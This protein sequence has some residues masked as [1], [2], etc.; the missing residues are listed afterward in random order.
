MRYTQPSDFERL[1][2]NG[3]SELVEVDTSEACRL[4]ALSLVRQAA[5]RVDILSR[6]LDPAMYDTSEFSEAVSRLVIN[7]RRARVRILLRQV[8]PVVKHGHRL[9][10]LAQRLSSFIELRVP[11]GE[12]DDYN[13]AFLMVD[14]AGVIYR[15][16]PA[17]FEATV[18][19]SDRRMAQELG[20]QFDEMWQTATP[21][22]NLQR[23]YL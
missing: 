5:R 13:P 15:T 12:F 2:L 8:E 16:L 11:S 1:V 23:S 18:S 10:A 20:R 19:F 17:R 4:A 22:M 6:N 9:V 3:H 14:D 7:S 21:D